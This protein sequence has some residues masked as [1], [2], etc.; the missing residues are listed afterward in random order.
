MVNYPKKERPKITKIKCVICGGEMKDFE[1]FNGDTCAK[2]LINK[3][4]KEVC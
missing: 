2:C 4:K 1:V 3:K